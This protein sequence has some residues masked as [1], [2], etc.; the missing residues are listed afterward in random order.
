M[1]K[2]KKFTELASS[3]Q[4][5]SLNRSK[6]V[7]KTVS[8]V[9]RNHVE[10]IP[11]YGGEPAT[12]PLFLSACEYLL[13]EFC[14][15]TQATDPINEYLLRVII[16]KL[17]GRAL[18]LIGSREEPRNWD[19]LKTLLENYFGD[20]RD[21]QCL[22]RDLQ[23][24]RPRKGETPYHFGMRVQDVRGLLLT[25]LKLA[26][27]E[28]DTRKIK[29]R[30]YDDI[31]LQTYLRGLPENLRNTIRAQRPDSVEKAMSLIIEEENF[32]YTINRSSSLNEQSNFRPSPKITPASFKPQQPQQVH[33]G[34]HN[35][36]PR[37]GGNQQMV[38]YRQNQNYMQ[39]PPRNPF[40]YVRPPT[41]NPARYAA[42]TMPANLANQKPQYNP[43]NRG[44]PMETDSGNS[45]FSR[46]PRNMPPPPQNNHPGWTSQELFYQEVPEMGE[47]Y[48]GEEY[49]PNNVIIEEATDGMNDY[50]DNYY[51]HQ[52][53]QNV[54]NVPEE[55]GEDFYRAK[56]PNIPK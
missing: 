26:V 2:D 48:Y 3:I 38:Q 18:L 53:A 4:Q 29:I 5:L 56:P 6:M 47:I 27:K 19:E 30:I 25:K 7:N 45:R 33:T 11:R 39:M 42:P 16:S 28:A 44:E 24:L 55:N 22:A 15:Q 14:N 41:F 32:N 34:T 51:A 31:A 49:S 46:Q 21:E 9:T 43:H 8:D 36:V 13:K 52:P 40:T 54:E 1:S 20:Q 17:D 12:L 37:H 23:D 10:V 35:F 50:A